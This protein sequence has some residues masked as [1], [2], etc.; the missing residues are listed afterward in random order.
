M[1][2]N[3]L[4]PLTF[5]SVGRQVHPGN[6]P[7]HFTKNERFMRNLA[8]TSVGL[9]GIPGQP[10]SR[11][12]IRGLRQVFQERGQWHRPAEAD[13]SASSN[14]LSGNRQNWPFPVLRYCIHCRSSH[15]CGNNRQKISWLP[16]L[17]AKNLLVVI[18]VSSDS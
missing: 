17:Q 2:S 5:G 4:E 1:H 18:W 16:L 6:E 13:R 3:G 7:L 9:D 10:V 12:R 14:M 15:A 8:E 11:L